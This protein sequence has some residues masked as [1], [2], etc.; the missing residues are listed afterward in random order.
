M[1]VFSLLFL[2]A[3]SPLWCVFSTSRQKVRSNLP[4]LRPTLSIS[5]CHRCSSSAVTAFSACTL[6]GMP[7]A[8]TYFTPFC[9]IF[10]VLHTPAST[11]INFYTNQLL[12]KPAAFTQTHFSTNHLLHQPAL[13]QTSF[14]THTSF[15]TNQ[16]FRPT[17][18]TQPL[19][20]V[21][22]PQA[23]GPECRRPLNK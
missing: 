21:C 5:T 10:T 7:L 14:Y 20:W 8:S 2:S 4:L 13:T 12:H 19:L 9:S 22:R 15:Y 11:Q 23:T 6:T 3:G 16:P 18:F 17:S 1:S